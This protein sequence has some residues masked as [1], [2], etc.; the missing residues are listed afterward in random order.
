M[1]CVRD[2]AGRAAG[3]LEAARRGGIMETR[4]PRDDFRVQVAGDAEPRS[5]AARVSFAEAARERLEHQGSLVAVGELS[6]AD[7]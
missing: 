6:K 2:S 5:A 4:R 3:S 1:P 7:L